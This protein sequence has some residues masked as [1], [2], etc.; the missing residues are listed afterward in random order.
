[1]LKLGAEGG[2]EIAFA[3]NSR[4]AESL[5]DALLSLPQEIEHSFEK[6]PH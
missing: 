5:G 6:K 4:H 1:M 2:F 3:L